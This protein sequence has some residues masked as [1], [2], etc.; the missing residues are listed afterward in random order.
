[1]QTS[2][3]LKRLVIAV[4]LAFVGVSSTVGQTTDQPTTPPAQQPPAP[5]RKTASSPSGPELPSQV[6]PECLLQLRVTL[7]VREQ[8]RTIQKQKADLA[9]RV[10]DNQAQQQKT[11]KRINDL[12]GRLHALE[13]TGGSAKDPDTGLTTESHFGAD[14]KVHITVKETA[15]GKPI[16]ERTEERGSGA[17]IQKDL[18]SANAELTA[19]QKAAADLAARKPQL[20][21]RDKT[22]S[23]QLS[24]EVSRLAKCLE[25]HCKELVGKTLNDV[26]TRFG[27]DP[28]G[29]GRMPPQPPTTDGGGAKQ[30]PAS[31]GDGVSPAPGGTGQGAAPAGGPELPAQVC[32]ECLLQLRVTLEIRE[33]WRTIQKQQADLRQKA[34]DNQ[35]QQTKTQARIKSLEA[36]LH[37][38]E[39]TGGSGRDPDTGLTTEAYTQ[40]DGRVRVQV[41][42]GDGNVVEE[43]WRDRKDLS[44]VQRDI[45]AANAELAGLKK[46]AA[47]FEAERQ[48][49]DAR[50][51]TVSDQLSNEVSRLAKCL[52]EH[53]KQLVGLRLNDVA[54]IFGLDPNG[55]GRDPKP[56]PPTT[57]VRIVTVITDLKSG[58]VNTVVQNIIISRIRMVVENA[59]RQASTMSSWSS[60]QQFVLGWLTRRAAPL[61]SLN[62]SRV[63]G[64]SR[65]PR[66][67]DV[68]AFQSDP[69]AGSGGGLSASIVASGGSTGPVFT[70]QARNT[71]GAPVTIDEPDGLVLQ[72]LKQLAQT[73][74]QKLVGSLQSQAMSGYC[75]DF[76]KLPPSAGTLFKVADEAVQRQ[77]APMKNILQAARK[78]T[79]EGRLHPD[80]DPTAYGDATRQWAIWSRLGN[81]DAKAFEEHFVD[82]T[83]KNVEASR[84]KW[85]KALEQRVRELVPNRWNDITQVWS[86]A[87][88]LSAG[89]GR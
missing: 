60:F 7:A 81:W 39:G 13:G 58:A 21:A 53:C 43:R 11:Q 67:G 44:Q 29:G 59:A 89:P 30:P 47:G 68:V 64:R 35:A 72:P 75:L 46:E 49:L 27:L 28:A 73:A 14:G 70:L 78:L 41:K 84:Q 65:L 61:A 33:Q 37:S 83:H 86:E 56:T 16:S 82:R 15:T 3:T 6:C 12:E 38:Q 10:A 20:D 25:E 17:Q 48:R 52:E 88:A 45:D 57:S 50:G 32:P 51:K 4:C 8:W 71:T 80:S 63:L 62:Q 85:T 9:Q 77:Y 54:T 40:P 19:L 55:G 36:E 24:N 79:D 23:D 22:V 66:P 69:S 74:S 76:A 26:A 31:G 34:A 42:D 1:M 18:A 87:D 5:G 2:F